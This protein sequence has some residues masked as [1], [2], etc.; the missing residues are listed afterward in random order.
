MRL[1]RQITYEAKDDVEALSIARDR[2][3]REAIILSSRSE[4]RGGF[5]GFFRRK[6]LVVTAGLLEEEE[7][8]KQERREDA[9]E[10]IKA[11]QRLLEVK[12]AVREAFP[13]PPESSERGG[14]FPRPLGQEENSSFPEP[15]N[16]SVPPVSAEGVSFA[17]SSMARQLAVKE[18]ALAS[19][20]G[21]DSEEH[22]NIK[23]E[24][25][26]I[27]GILR[28]ILQRF[29]EREDK[30]PS[31][32]FSPP[33]FQEI[34]PGETP[35]PEPPSSG[36][37]PLLGALLAQDLEF[38]KASNLL[39]EYRGS[40]MGVPFSRWLASR[41][42]VTGK[43]TGEALGGKR[44]L[45]VGPT[46]V[47]KTTTIAK[48]AAIFSLWEKKSVLLLTADTYRIAAVEQLKM[49]ARILGVPFRVIQNPG[50]VQPLLKEYEETDIVLID[51]AGRCQKD[52]GKMEELETL[53]NS[54]N[55]DVVH[56]VLAANMKTRD[57]KDV[58]EHMT[59]P[60]SGV[61]FTKLD[62][63]LSF[64]ALLEVLLESRLPMSFVTAG[65]NVPNDIDVAESFAFA[66]L[67][68]GGDVHVSSS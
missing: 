17:F 32:D 50:D 43:S 59:V 7:P 23:Q 18:G 3:G 51:T 19:V 39:Q 61:V 20:A 53:Y 62:E 2:L 44:A 36:E 67:F 65:Q 55:P 8:Q 9:S 29:P 28:D 60:L 31:V 13:V 37:D 24:I 63:T 5:L 14:H 66:Q 58:L 25:E 10:R 48:L 21:K 40:Q 16:S 11:F 1:V 45:F 22:Q 49:Y 30:S 15:K 68:E 47:G 52:G 34:S 56:L 54:L 33:S 38:R 42:S 26:E 12:Q 46:G 35:F 27:R 41:I 6:A 57:M 4:A 64:G